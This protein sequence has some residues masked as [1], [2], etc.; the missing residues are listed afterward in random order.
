[1]SVETV[2]RGR[3]KKDPY[4]HLADINRAITTSL[5]F[6]QVLRLIVDNAADLV[7]A[8]IS[9]LLL[10]D[11][12]QRLSIRASFG[13][14][15]KRGASFFGRMEEDV[16]KQL[17]E[18]L[19]I[20]P[21]Q[22]LVSVPI[23]AQNAVEG[24]LVIVRSKP[25]HEEES[26]Q[27]S[28]LADQAAIALGNA[29]LYEMELA[30]ANR[31]RDET[32]EALRNANA[33]VTRILESITDLFYQLDEEWRFTDVNRQTEL[34]LG[35]SRSELLGKVIWDV[36]PGAVDSILYPM[37]HTAVDKMVATHFEVPSKLTPGSWFEGHAYP[38]G[39]GLTVYL[40]DI[41]ERKQSDMARRLLS[42]IVEFSD[43]A[44][45][46]KNL[47]G[48]ILSWNL[49]AERIF[50]Y[51]A[52]EAIGKPITL[53]IPEERWHEEP[54]IIRQIAAGK[55]LEHYETVRQRKDGTLLDISVT[56]S[57]MRDEQGKVIGASKIARD[58]TAQ[59]AAE[60]EIRF[61]AHL[62]NAVEQ[63]VIATDLA[64]KVIYWNNFAE[65]LYGWSAAE[66]V[67]SNIFDLTPA[68][69]SKDRAAEIFA[70]L[71]NGHSWTGELTL[72]RRDGSTF[73][74]MITDSPITNDSGELMGIVGVSVDI[75]DEKIAEQERQRLLALEQNAREA[76][77]AANR[78]K[79]EFL[80]TL[81]HEL[82]NPLNVV[83]GYAEILRRSAQSHD[84]AFVAK[85]AEV[86]RRN[87]LA[88]SQ[89]VSDLL[90]LSRLQM[91]KLAINRQPVSL[92]MIITDAIETVRTEA[93]AKQIQLNLK[94]IDETILVTGDPVRLGQIAWNLLNNAVKFTP[95]GGA[96]T[97]SLHRDEQS[98]CLAIEDSGQG[99][100]PTFLPHV[101]EIFRQADGSSARKQGGLGIGL[102]LVKQL[103]E[104]HNG[105]VKAE[106]KGVG[107]GAK[108]TVCMPMR[109]DEVPESG[110]QKTGNTGVLRKKFI[111]VVDDS[112]ETT[113]MLCRLLEMEGAFV[114]TA[115]SGEEAL[116]L[117]NGK[118]FDLIISDISM[119]E[120][121]GYELL[122][123]LRKLPSMAAVPALALTG[124]GRSSDKD[125]AKDEGFMRHLTKP[126]DIDKLLQSVRE[127]TDDQK[128]NPK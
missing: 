15:P 115:R 36:F 82:R 99:I 66:A 51:K 19:S 106:S 25:L 107:L 91:G 58:V 5:D 22:S 2:P 108:F 81:S 12:D 88:Q 78:V 84:S 40:R 122:Q 87:A 68:I 30:E 92:T 24:L 71:K 127:L 59:K 17:S 27:L 110:R 75:T 9:L 52:E 49:G 96:I 102:A 105:Q 3:T 53:I 109:E 13:I 118:S 48:I 29:R 77:E 26:W 125:R 34:R 38:T 65:S 67:G 113:E 95:E 62:L 10:S 72:R 18:Q 103:A 126:L 14:D 16:I 119:P 31:E 90:D 128:L 97:V 73:P 28:A 57:P 50:G 120:M 20:H 121:D 76:A 56:V 74:A 39:T 85:A 123:Q 116:A 93:D 94:N 86:I 117:A 33:R 7:D 80:A 1:M 124:F 32:L 101:F 69:E 4:K 46:S 47:D 54:E 61:Q 45:I 111:L 63:A 83:I 89:L 79:D 98:A 42:S 43:D 37:L 23:I 114:W 41:T 8:D 11:Q 112:K 70:T 6:D 60:Q 21:D 44:I 35:K 104:L 64:G 55:S 100:E